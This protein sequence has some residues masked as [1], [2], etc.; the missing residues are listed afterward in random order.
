MYTYFL[1]GAI[2]G[3]Y[4][5]SIC[6]FSLGYRTAYALFDQCEVYQGH[7]RIFILKIIDNH[8]HMMNILICNLHVPPSLF[9]KFLQNTKITFPYSFPRS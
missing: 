6:N 7:L 9:D 4:L 3:L 5:L 8:L 1:R 2:Y